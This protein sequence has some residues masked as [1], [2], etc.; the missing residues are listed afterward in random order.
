MLKAE[1]VTTEAGITWW[2]LKCWNTILCSHSQSFYPRLSNHS[3]YQD[4]VTMAVGFGVRH[5]FRYVQ[6][7]SEQPQKAIKI[8]DIYC[9]SHNLAASCGMQRSG[10]AV[11]LF[12]CSTPSNQS[13]LLR[14]KPPGQDS[15]G[16]TLYNA[17]V[18]LPGLPVQYP[19]KYKHQ[20]SENLKLLWHITFPFPWLLAVFSGKT[21]HNTEQPISHS[22][23]QSF[24]STPVAVVP[25]SWPLPFVILSCAAED[26]IQWKVAHNVI[27]PLQCDWISNFP[28]K[29]TCQAPWHLPHPFY[30]HTLLSCRGF[31][32]FTLPWRILLKYPCAYLA[33]CWHV[34][35]SGQG[36]GKNAMEKAELLQCLSSLDGL[37]HCGEALPPA[38]P[39]CKFCLYVQQ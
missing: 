30:C 7:L 39:S 8:P 32:P 27:L 19:V 28:L 33:D 13:G 38:I 11:N 15:E 23:W 20:F 18:S 29:P 31:S 6:G 35:C 25:S 26:R 16:M 3:L 21:S 5:G 2:H 4:S 34:K 14:G 36:S 17:A 1:N 22:S 24:L 10:W 9:C 12:M 37:I